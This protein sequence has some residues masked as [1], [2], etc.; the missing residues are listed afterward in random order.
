MSKAPLNDA[1]IVAISK[2]VDDAQAERRE[3]SHNG[4]EQEVKRA[5]LGLGDPKARGE[6]VGKAKRVKAILSWAYENDE[7]AG[8]RFIYQLVVLIRGHGGFRESSPN[9]IGREAIDNAAAA[10]AAE[11]YELSNDG[12]LRPRILDNLT[13]AA[14]TEA[15]QAY[16]RRAKV[17][18]SDAALV[19][20]TGK[21]LLEAVAAHIIQQKFGSYSTT[22]NFPTLLGQTF[23]ALGLATSADPT[24][25]GEPPN[26]AIER[27]MF[28][29][30]CAINRLRNKQGTG[31][32]RPWL[33]TITDAEARMATEAMGIIAERLLGLHRGIK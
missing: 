16:V 18:A 4:I 13:G 23:I 22:S 1:I 10:F 29:L 27:A 12:E 5:G 30:A 19:T 25:S 14:L 8:Q 21:D 26:K 31:H 7:L 28:D 24:V 20:G 17:G 6:S 32:G 11:G 15:L 33:P 9:F 2:M 3:P